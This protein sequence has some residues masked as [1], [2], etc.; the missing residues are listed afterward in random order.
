MFANNSS[1]VGAAVEE[2]RGPNRSFLNKEPPFVRQSRGERQAM[3][4]KTLDRRVQRTRRQL[5]EA[6]MSLVRDKRYDAIKVQD[7]LNRADVG[8]ST[9]YM[10]FRDKEDL[11]DSGLENLDRRVRS[12]QATAEPPSDKPYERIIGFSLAMF[13]HASQFRAMHRALL[14]SGAEAI[15]RR[16]LH[17]VLTEVVSRE[18]ESQLHLRKQA[19][20]PVSTE[21]LTHFLV[22]AYS[23]T[24]NWWITSKNALTP[25]QIDA[26]YRQLVLPC[27]ASIFE[28]PQTRKSA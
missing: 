5:H 2:Q 8:R 22:S 11:L 4:R 24:L 17:S 1:I 15:M 16:R 9:F 23:S 10:H 21:L 6:L 26:A 19:K 20:S 14:G 7:I 18:I 13:E 25:K 3:T 28:E 12:A 27:L